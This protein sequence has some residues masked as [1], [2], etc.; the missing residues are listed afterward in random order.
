[1]KL[2]KKMIGILCLSFLFN[3][4]L[5][6]QSGVYVGG[7]AYYDT[8]FSINELKTSGFTTAIVWT[9]H[10]N[11]VGDLNFN[12]E[13]LVCKDGNYVGDQKYKDFPKNMA[14]LKT[15]PTSIN[16]LE[17]GLSAWGSS[18]FANIK[19]LIES[20]GT[21]ENSILYKNFKALKETIPAFDAI[22]FDDES[23][24][25]EPSSTQFA[26]ML[27]DLGFKVSLV[28]YTASTYWTNLAKNT[29]SQRPGAVDIVYLQ[30]YAG[31][32]SNSPCDWTG[33]FDDIP[34]YPGLWGSQIGA[35]SVQ[36]RMEGYNSNCGSE[37]GFIWIY[38]EI[39]NSV[40]VE[41]LA[42]AINNAF[43]I[44]YNLNSTI[45]SPIPIPNAY[46]V[47]LSEGLSWTAGE[48]AVSHD[49]YFGTSVNP[50]FIGN[51]T[52][53]LFTPSNLTEN[54]RYFWRVDEISATDTIV[55]NVYTFHSVFPVPELA[56]NPKPENEAT[57]I[58]L[59]QSLSWDR[60]LYSTSYSLYLGINSSLSE[61]DFIAE[62]SENI[63]VPSEAF[64]PNIEYYWRVDSKNAT[65]ITTGS[66]WS[67]AT[68]DSGAV[69]SGSALDFNGSNSKVTIQNSPSL[70]VS[71][72]KITIEAW[73][74]PEL[75]KSET[76]QGSVVL[77]DYGGGAGRD[78][79][80]GLRC[81]GQGQFDVVLGSGNWQELKSPQNSISLN[82]W[83][84]I[85]ATF[86]GT[87]I[88][89]YV[90]GEEVAARRASFSIVTNS[91][92]VQI[93]DSPGFSGRVFNG[94][95]DEVRIWNIART[96]EEIKNSMNLSLGSGILDSE[97]SGLV[98]Y[99][100]MDEGIDQQVS[101]KSY[102]G[103]DG[104][105]GSSSSKES[106]DPTWVSSEVI[107]GISE[108]NDIDSVPVE[109]KLEQNYPNPFNPT[110]N[111]SFSLPEDSHVKLMVY[112]VCGSLVEVLENNKLTKGR[113]TKTWDAENLSS[114]MYFV[115]INTDSF[116]KTIKTILL[117]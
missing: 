39:K 21:G 106:S 36:S 101:D 111:I 22:N 3:I 62:V 2:N 56:E 82:V 32:S 88:K 86:N 100:S 53:T 73:V 110:T 28:P 9:I 90:N 115:R 30:C 97:S 114:G 92:N 35:A 51:Q 72:N 71:G 37:G 103:N 24:Y 67:F 64:E 5:I 102:F 76:W 44:T 69:F 77:K 68:K 31:G 98:G 12:G 116:T 74:N 113:Y 6:G 47:D 79:G 112:N 29:N 33:Y 19:S 84:H 40:A 60:A 80:Y 25:D 1:M 15:A 85:A 23:T 104:L 107:V 26:I 81:G 43:G 4:L 11:G 89:L 87:N 75:F 66:T 58:V 83:T 52:E 38:D 61:S 93:G 16:R 14:L 34:V 63:Y 10:I 108:E 55:G 46:E 50:D 13:F 70:S 59:T 48:N 94:K 105:L 18:T 42:D 20:E 65:G 96:E 27:A 54:T 78:Y 45:S 7:P 95:I 109:F 91:N 17:V 117:K 8:E 41:E 57:D 99:W 49:V